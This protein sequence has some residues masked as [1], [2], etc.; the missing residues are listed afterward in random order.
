M[1]INIFGSETKDSI[2]VG[3]I[4]PENGLDENVSVCEANQ[5]AKLNPGTQFSFRSGDTI[6]FLNINEVNKLTPKDLK[7]PGKCPGIN[8]DA[9]C[10]GPPQVNFYGGGGIGA[11]ANAVVGKDGSVLAVDLISGG[12]GYQYPPIVEVS[13][14]CGLG[15]GVVAN[16]VLGEVSEIIE[17]FGDTDLEIYEICSPDDPGY[18]KLY[19]PNGREIGNWDPRLYISSAERT[20]QIELRKYQDFLKNIKNPWFTT[21]KNPPKKVTFQNKTTTVKYDVKSKAW[22]E[23]MNSHAISPV[24]A[25]DAKSSDFAD[26]PFILEWEQQFPFNGEYI[27]RGL[28]D[29]KSTLYIDG[30]KISDLNKV[31]N[32]PTVIKRTVKSGLHKIRIDLRNEPVLQVPVTPT[33]PAIPV[34]TPTTATT[35]K[36]VPG[37]ATVE[38]YKEGSNYFVKVDGDEGVDVTVD[39]SYYASGDNT[40]FGSGVGFTKLTIDTEGGPQSI[41]RKKINPDYDTYTIKSCKFKTGKKYKIN[42]EGR[43]FVLS[44]NNWVPLYGTQE[45]TISPSKKTLVIPDGTIRVTPDNKITDQG[46][47]TAFT[48]EGYGL[49]LFVKNVSNR[50]VT[51]SV[52]QSIPTKSLASNLN[53]GP[54]S[55]Y[56]FNTADFI[57]KANRKLW[58]SNFKVDKESDFVNRYGVLPFNP[59]TGEA[60]TESYQGR[61]SIVWNNVTFPKDGNYIIEIMADDSV[62][63]D[64]SSANQTP[65]TKV[66]IN[67]QGF[68]DR[69]RS[70]G[71]RTEKRFFKAGTYRIGAELFQSSGLQLAKGNNMFL[72]VNIQSELSRTPVALPKSWNENPVGVA[73]VIDAPPPPQPKLAPP[74]Q[75]GRCP[76]NPTWSTRFLN[77]KEKWWNVNSIGAS[78]D[79]KAW[80]AF[81]NLYA[82]SPIAPLNTPNTDGGNVVYRNEWEFEAPQTG[83]YALQAAADNAAQIFIDGNLVMSTAASGG[84]PVVRPPS[85]PAVTSQNQRVVPQS[86]SPQPAAAAPGPVI[87]QVVLPKTVK[88]TV[89]ITLPPGPDGKPIPFETK[90][91][92]P[93]L[94]SLAKIDI[95]RD[96]N[97]ST[98][99][100]GATSITVESSPTNATFKNIKPGDYVYFYA[101]NAVVRSVSSAPK[102]TTNVIES[103]VSMVAVP[104]DKKIILSDVTALQKIKAGDIIKTGAGTSLVTGEVV[105]ISSIKNA[106]ILTVINEPIAQTS[107]VGSDKITL[108]GNAFNLVKRDDIFTFE[109][110]TK[111]V[112]SV[113]RINNNLSTIS[114]DSKI[115]QQIDRGKTVTITRELAKK[116]AVVVSLKSEIKNRIE[117]NQKVTI[118]R[119]TQRGI[120]TLEKPI[121][122][123]L[124]AGI[125]AG[126]TISI[127]RIQKP[128]RYPRVTSLSV[129]G[130]ASKDAPNYVQ[131]SGAENKNPGVTWSFTDLPQGVAIENYRVL[132][133]NLC[134]LDPVTKKPEIHWDITVPVGIT[135]IP[136]GVTNPKLIWGEN[137][138]PTIE[139]T[140]L[141]ENPK[142]GLSPIGYAGP[143]PAT[144]KIETY[145]LTVVAN[146][147]GSPDKLVLKRLFQVNPDVI[148]GRNKFLTPAPGK[149][150]VPEEP[151]TRRPDNG[152][153]EYTPKTAE[154]VFSGT[155][156]RVDAIGKVVPGEPTGAIAEFSLPIPGISTQPKLSNA[157][158][159][160]S[161][162]G[163]YT[164]SSA[165]VGNYF[166]PSFTP[167]NFNPYVSW[168]FPAPPDGVTISSYDIVLQCISGDQASQSPQI[169]WDIRVPSNITSIPYNADASW[170]SSNVSEIR[171]NYLMNIGLPRGGTGNNAGVNIIGYSGPQPKNT[172]SVIYR[173]SVTAILTGANVSPESVTSAM[174]F[175]FI[176]SSVGLIP[177]A[178]NLTPKNPNNRTVKYTPSFK[179]ESAR[180]KLDWLTKFNIV[181]TP[182]TATDPTKSSTQPFN[183]TS[184]NIIPFQMVGNAPKDDNPN[185]YADA[186]N[187]HPSVKWEL[188]EFPEDVR[189]IV[190]VK[191]YEIL[192][193]D[194]NEVDPKKI[195]TKYQTPTPKAPVPLI[196]WNVLIPADRRADKILSASETDNISAYVSNNRIQVEEN[197]IGKNKTGIND[198]GYSGPQPP[199]SESHEY[200]LSFT[201]HFEENSALFTKSITKS[202]TLKYV[203]ETELLTVV[204]EK[205]IHSVEQLKITSLTPIASGQLNT[206]PTTPSPTS[207]P[208]QPNARD[209]TVQTSSLLLEISPSPKEGEQK[210]SLPKLN[211]VAPLSMVGNSENN[212]NEYTGALNLNPEVKW[213]F[214]ELPVGVAVSSY[215]VILEDLS[216]V[217]GDTEETEKPTLHWDITVPVGITTVPAGVTDVK[218][219]WGEQT[220]VI[221]ETYLGGL[222]TNGVTAIGYAGPQPPT[223]ESHTYRLSVTANLSGNL[224]T[225]SRKSITQSQI[226]FFNDP[227]GTGIERTSADNGTAKKRIEDNLEFTYT[228]NPEVTSSSTLSV[229]QTPARKEITIEERQK[230]ISTTIR[231]YL[232]TKLKQTQS[233]KPNTNN[234]AEIDQK[235]FELDVLRD[236]INVANTQT[237]NT[238][239]KLL[240]L[241]PTINARI[242]SEQKLIKE[243][244]IKES[245]KI[246]IYQTLLK[247][248]QKIENPTP[249]NE[250]TSSSSTPKVGSPSTILNP[251]T[252]ESVGK[253]VNSKDNNPEPKKITLTKGKHT[254]R[255]EVVNNNAGPS[256]LTEQKIFSTKDWMSSK[257]LPVQ[258]KTFAPGK[259][260][261]EYYKEGSNYFVKVD[262]DEGV[263]VTVDFTYDI[264]ESTEALSGV[265]FR[266][267]T[268]E[269]E[270]GPKSI[271]R[272][273]VS[274]SD[275]FSYSIKSC[276][277]KTNKKY[278]ITIEGAGD[279]VSGGRWVPSPGKPQDPTISTTK[280][281]LFLPDRTLQ[282][283]DGKIYDLGRVTSLTLEGIGLNLNVRSVSNR[284]ILSTATDQ[285]IST[286]K[287]APGIVY[288]GPTVIA[289]YKKD[290]ISPKLKDV[291]SQNNEEL[292]GKTWKF[293]WTNVNFPETGQ[294][295]LNVEGDDKVII[296]INGL[297][298]AETEMPKGDPEPRKKI[299]FNTVKGRKTVEI[300]LINFAGN[301]PTG[302][303][304]SPEGAV[305]KSRGNPALAFLEITRLSRDSKDII[306]N[307]WKENP[308]GVSAVLTPPPCPRKIRGRGPIIN[309]PIT[310]GGNGFSPSENPS[311]VTPASSG[312]E[313]N[314]PEL[315]GY[316]VALVPDTPIITGSPINYNCSE[317]KI[318]INNI[319]VPFEC[320]PFGVITNIII[321]PDFPPVTTYPDIRIETQTGVGLEFIIP[322]KVVRDPIDVPPQ[323]LLQVT[324]LVGLKQTGY[325][326]GRPY[327]GAIFYEDGIA[328]AGFYRTPGPLVRVYAT[329]QESIDAQ[330]TTPPSAIQRQ[331]TDISSNNPRLNIPGTPQDLT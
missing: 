122:T 51:T 170:V 221:G 149:T 133:E 219:I 125:P 34:S 185:Q 59:D 253:L 323:Q 172:Q 60:Q 196:H 99:L 126:Q 295:T 110:I 156:N 58:R 199:R 265:T 143:Q 318:F 35:E 258:V 261:V 268:I 25:S 317:D 55:N 65:R 278:K 301:G 276:K 292:N 162:T 247:D 315:P 263:D 146:L 134:V 181:V 214:G 293:R 166:T 259:A 12:Y 123:V 70:T 88:G 327:Y 64:I 184:K 75:E 87:S 230:N 270:E 129:Y 174:Q 61:H 305:I 91:V 208:T 118:T 205:P 331:G 108:S 127:K 194:L 190:K 157:S 274:P 176:N 300:E 201:A 322:F 271:N 287:T 290:Y 269:T 76:N 284:T 165:T 225:N 144:D 238:N 37:K 95:H 203:K 325:V 257:T 17:T 163:I 16:A 167:Q 169:H 45:P 280:K 151:L 138:T 100:N 223:N 85:V 111:K 212:P 23:F 136:A 57:G 218:T 153:I 117:K 137:G 41:V 102:T 314:V 145:Q 321:P 328:Y 306:S 155:D 297:K 298:V 98:V 13:D 103:P 67:H 79:S 33:I 234:K 73:L 93:T 256:K 288:E 8:L 309:V 200:K 164:G 248:I 135:T 28:C 47:I 96:K 220:P 4:S 227:S 83:T 22:N 152:V 308:I 236:L 50:V 130:N 5:I 112:V 262:G 182:P 180:K 222:G 1:A 264:A 302:F 115:T 232:D 178:S 250:S 330:V 40:S 39:F 267:L 97:V 240:T 307:S 150:N 107:A 312:S 81:M 215:R 198:I 11:K 89:N 54:I 326:N 132:L 286:S 15:N 319:S 94:E 304:P 71:K 119:E 195:S 207:P 46:R 31:N 282:V 177:A 66:V 142:N 213:S 52:V 211:G 38:Y 161:I 329:L 154:Y 285:I 251:V 241:V 206:N 281:T 21:R 14:R 3:R 171:N 147:I 84:P 289:N 72:A 48:L 42:F 179:N 216:S 224:T 320:N 113:S 242:A 92:E 260:N 188:E 9:K 6:K 235:A 311:P 139:K 233:K 173:L 20:N 272:R 231:T 82:I 266:K 209:F 202:V 324:D 277:F 114:L 273:I 116:D 120:I 68:D 24:P 80:G 90:F 243:K 19:G 175:S 158:V 254:I 69:R 197:Y 32:S 303:W 245:K 291:N 316:P 131:Y 53:Q 310:D 78:G 86:T 74:Q 62:V 105:G 189:D 204:P 121:K 191:E 148:S 10:G 279:Y 228:P 187:R 27:F 168:Q 49:N 186:E 239:I 159:F 30:E 43:G 160:S 313:P 29:S 226:F 255:V 56:V 63:L 217:E 44:N 249:A 104:G 192:L 283:I 2:R 26:V 210:Q 77:S 275:I 109:K 229:A 237:L 128:E 296:R 140:Y 183:D 124:P 294:Y 141:G 252:S 36:T 7:S 106:D 244:K 101:N 299:N 18:G 193:E 246:P